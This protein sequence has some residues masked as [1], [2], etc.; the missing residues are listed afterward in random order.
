MGQV[1]ISA[2]QSTIRG[3]QKGLAVEELIADEREAAEQAAV[4]R[5]AAQEWASQAAAEKASDQTWRQTA[6]QTASPTSERRS[7]PPTARAAYPAAVATKSWRGSSRSWGSMQRVSNRAAM[8]R[9]ALD[10]SLLER[11]AM[12]LEREA[13]QQAVTEGVGAATTVQAAIRG[14][15]ARQELTR[16]RAEAAAEVA[17][18]EVAAGEAEAAEGAAR[19]IKA[20]EE[21]REVAAAEL[22]AAKLEMAAATAA[23]AAAAETRTIEAAHEVDVLLLREVREHKI[24]PANHPPRPHGRHPPPRRSVVRR[25]S[26]RLDVDLSGGRRC[27][28]PRTHSSC[29]R[30]AN[31]EVNRRDSTPQP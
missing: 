1:W 4:E 3:K 22:A 7:S 21:E 6:A 29:T 23:T 16:A 5:H 8:E 11:S 31:S 17:A 2:L 14:R 18:A 12:V 26:V 9:Q 24:R 28:K 19:A 25:L 13:A 15:N 10:R 27:H 20:A 30:K